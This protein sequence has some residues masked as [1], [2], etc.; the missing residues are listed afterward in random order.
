MSDEGP[1]PLD[2]HALNPTGRF[3]E[4]ASDY[5]RFRPDYP[6][7]AL[8][9]ILAGLGDPSSLVA[10]DLGAGTGISARMLAA[11]GV[12]VIAVEPNA[13]M[14]DAAE[15][16]PAVRWKDGTGEATGLEDGTVDLVLSAQAFH[17][18]RK[19]E[20]IAECR[21]ILC[22]SGRLALMWNERDAS[23]PLTHRFIEAIRAVNGEHAI[24][25]MPFDPDVVHADGLF[26]PTRLEWFPHGQALDLGG[27]V[28]RATS[29]SYVPREGP[30][31][32]RLGGLLEELHARH[33]DAQG[34]VTL[35]YSTKLYL[36]EPVAPSGG[37]PTARRRAS[38]R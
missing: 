16:H 27:L 23:D 10:A 22:R 18:F 33:R 25:R 14:R 17:W 9:A 28:G 35:R 12:R 37:S 8:D 11:R 20:V 13:E 7:A 3:S 29:A 6:A 2:L 19:R 32:E 26:T 15:P 24:E 38:E 36:A 21:R 34:L 5:R 30:G 31:L 4:R 1:E